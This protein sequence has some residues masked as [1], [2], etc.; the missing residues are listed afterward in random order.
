MRLEVRTRSGNPVFL[1]FAE[2]ASA[3]DDG[4]QRQAEARPADMPQPQTK[5]DASADQQRRIAEECED[6]RDDQ[7]EWATTGIKRLVE[8]SIGRSAAAEQHRQP[9]SGK[10]DDCDDEAPL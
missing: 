3:D 8:G 7:Q 5:H 2:D 10:S 4:D 6:A 1:S 9:D